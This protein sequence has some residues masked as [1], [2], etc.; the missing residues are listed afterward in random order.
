MEDEVAALVSLFG[1]QVAGGDHGLN[2]LDRLLI[3]VPE[4]ARLDVRPKIMCYFDLLTSSIH[5]CWYGGL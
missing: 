3:M 5:S 2:R 4:C 1:S